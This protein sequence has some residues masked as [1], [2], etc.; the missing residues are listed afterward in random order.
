MLIKTVL[1]RLERF[2]SIMFSMVTLQMINGSEAMVV[3][4]KARANSKP[5]RPECGK[6][7]E[8]YDTLPPRL[9]E[10]VPI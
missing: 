2:K 1:N 9:F 4:I 5:E 10:Y 8:K 6:R 7:G 3:G